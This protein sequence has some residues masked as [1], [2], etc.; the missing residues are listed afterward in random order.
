MVIPPAPPAIPQLTRARVAELVAEYGVA[1]VTQDP[2]RIGA[3]FS[4]E[5]AIYIERP[6][7]KKATF[8]GR[9][10]ISEYWRRQ[11]VGKQSDIRF[12]HLE[13]DMVV[14]TEQNRA[15]VT[16]MAAFVN[17]G[18]KQL[19]RFRQVAVLRFCEG[20]THISYLEE[21][22]RPAPGG[23]IK[24][25]PPIGAS[26]EQASAMLRPC[27]AVVAAA[28]VAAASAAVVARRRSLPH[29]LQAVDLG[30]GVAV[31]VAHGAPIVDRGSTFL[32]S[33]AFPVVDQGAASAALQR[34][35]AS[36]QHAGADHHVTA[37]RYAALPSAAS[38]AVAATAAPEMPGTPGGAKKEAV[39]KG[40]NDGGEA[41]GGQRLCGMMQREGALNVV[42]LVSRWC[43]GG[44]GGGDMKLGKI[45]FEHIT[46]AGRALLQGC[47]LA[48]QGAALLQ[49]CGLAGQG[50]A[51]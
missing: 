29:P 17:R 21:Y 20:S 9:A 35:C 10:A 25:W 30:R 26:E 1:W 37:F 50:A 44:D 49:G 42:V 32:A 4:A 47:G 45:R 51:S 13:E 28:A 12:Q 27:C 31:H 34:L 24:G 16:W 43:G 14:D 7:D 19:C 22:N 23:R 39:V 3:L 2:E 8:E 5:N 11:V 46:G 15:T 33:L 40:H 48:G 41:H 6:Y 38:A 18:G 36:A